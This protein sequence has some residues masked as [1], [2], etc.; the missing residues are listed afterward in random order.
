[1]GLRPKTDQKRE[2]AMCNSALKVVFSSLKLNW[3][4]HCSALSKTDQQSTK[5]SDLSWSFHTYASTLTNG[6]KQI[7]VL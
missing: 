5:Q 1:M 3:I 2:K 4:S 7:F 6:E